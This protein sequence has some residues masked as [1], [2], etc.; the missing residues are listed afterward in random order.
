MMTGDTLTKF[1]AKVDTIIN[2]LGGAENGYYSVQLPYDTSGGMSHPTV[3]THAISADI[4]AHFIDKTVLGNDNTDYCFDASD[5][6]DHE[7]DHCGKVTTVCKNEDTDH[8]CDTDINCTAYA[9]C[10][11]DD[12]DHYCDLNCGA[13][14][15]FC[16]DT[17]EPIGICDVCGNDFAHTEADTN[18]DHL[19]DVC[20]ANYGEHKAAMGTHTCGHCGKYI[21]GTLVDFSG[22]NLENIRPKKP[23]TKVESDLG[24]IKIYNKTVVDGDHFGTTT[25]MIVDGHIYEITFTINQT[26]MDKYRPLFEFF[27]GSIKA[28]N[29]S[30]KSGH[31]GWVI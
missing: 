6:A 15:S 24:S 31:V 9:D 8:A 30:N 14:L 3:E 16:K 26:A 12:N 23:D 10:K 13:K 21:T 2:D 5:D 27:D 7:C 19:C 29:G 11:D 18:K 25:D 4:L 20:G 22:D 1:K 17:D 28:V